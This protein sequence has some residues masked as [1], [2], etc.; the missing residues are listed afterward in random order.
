MK[1]TN[2]NTVNLY[3]IQGQNSKISR[4]RIVYK[5]KTEE[6]KILY[7]QDNIY[8]SVNNAHHYYFMMKQVKSFGLMDA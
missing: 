1:I 4:K 5:N 7:P 2:I 6:V 8:L 3:R